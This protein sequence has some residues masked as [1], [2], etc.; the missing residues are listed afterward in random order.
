LDFEEMSHRE[1]ESKGDYQYKA[2]IGLEA[3]SLRGATKVVCLFY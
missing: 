1:M 3:P 2:L